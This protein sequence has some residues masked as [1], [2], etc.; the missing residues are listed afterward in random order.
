[1]MA[2]QETANTSAT[3][4]DLDILLSDILNVPVLRS[5]KKIGSLTDLVIAET[6]KIPEVRSLYVSRSFGNPSLLIPWE[7][8]HTLTGGELRSPSGILPH[9][10]SNRA[11]MS[12]S[13]GIIFSTRK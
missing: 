8:V 11:M 7:N 12:F 3:A 2:Q 10:K 9:M 6:T 4:G 1:M 13:F 5:G